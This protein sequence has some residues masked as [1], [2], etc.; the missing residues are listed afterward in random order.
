MNRSRIYS[1]SALA[2]ILASIGAVS[3]MWY[4]SLA[5]NVYV[6]TGTVA[7]EWSNWSCSDTGADPQ[8]PESGFDNSEDKDVASCIVTPE[9]I[10]DDGHTVKLNVTI[11]NAYPGYRAN[12]AMF[13][14]NVGTIPVKLYNY[15]ITGIDDSAMN[16]QFVIPTDTQIHPGNDGEYHLIIDILQTAQQN[17]TY[18]FE[19]ELGFAQ[20][21]EVSGAPIQ[22]TGP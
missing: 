3:A 5:I 9:I 20:W 21:N 8:T 4:Q 10:D 18:T 17:S 13:V 22:V 6:H 16:V 2:L 7:V 15:S 1:L 11:V 19:I 12:I 14:D